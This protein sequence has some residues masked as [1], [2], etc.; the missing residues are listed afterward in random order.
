MK[1]N[2]LRIGTRLAI[3]FILVLFLMLMM[4]GLS[5]Y[6][7]SSI[8]SNLDKVQQ[9]NLQ[10]IHDA[11]EM[12]INIDATNLHLHALILASDPRLKQQA[13]QAV[14][15]ARTG[16]RQSFAHLSSIEKT[17]TGKQLLKEITD[18]I[19]VARVANDLAVS[20]DQS[21]KP[22]EAAIQLMSNG[23]KIS[24][25]ETKLNELIAYEE[26]QSQNLT[27]VA[28]QEYQDSLVLLIML[29]LAALIIAAVC[30]FLV[31]RSITQP[32]SAMVDSTRLITDG[33]LQVRIR[34]VGRDEV[35][36]LADAF[37][38]MAD[39]IRVLVSQVIDKA[40]TVSASAQQ[41]TASSEQ[42]ASSANE[43]AMTISEVASAIDQL[44]GNVEKI[45]A[46]SQQ[47][48]IHA[49]TGYHGINQVEKQIDLISQSTSSVSLV[50]TALNRKAQEINQIVELIR[51]IAAQTNLLALNA[52]I[53][54]ARAGDQ[55]RGFA[56]VAE[57]VRKLAEQSAEAGKDILKLV[58]SIQEEASRAV[59]DMSHGLREVEIGINIAHEVSSAFEKIISQVHDLNGQITRVSAASNQI[60]EGVQNVAASTE[61]QTAAV[62]E[63]S[64]SA[65]AL[66]Q[67]A[68]ALSELVQIFQ[69]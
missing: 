56:V 14:E 20:L 13:S 29:S 44:N 28:H 53:E 6:Y 17:E 16:Y 48:V 39:K 19:A 58:S 51:S 7:I 31:T 66:S 27:D 35:A 15:Q 52:A 60:T 47:T 34:K 26:Q 10:Q 40:A 42:T 36:Q 62:E 63:V 68:V 11:Y 57:E 64:A 23:V 1:L 4:L 38:I 30:G 54:A 22:A 41:L 55:G 46:S 5:L 33:N 32:L 61:E 21:G 50:I 59:E 3:G 65:S 25:I 2:N 43:N 24:Q 49:D 9:L 37:S 18:A 8:Q 45:S 12:R 67:V 69:V